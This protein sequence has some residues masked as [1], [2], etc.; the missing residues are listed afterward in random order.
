MTVSYNCKSK[1]KENGALCMTVSYFGVWLWVCGL[2]LWHESW[3]DFVVWAWVWNLA[4]GLDS[5]SVF[6]IWTLGLRL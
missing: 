5:G 1:L 4:L 6:V 3:S 2:G